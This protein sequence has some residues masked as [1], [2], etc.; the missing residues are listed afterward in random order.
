MKIGDIAKKVGKDKADVADALG[1]EKKTGYWFKDVD[2]VKAEAY[3]AA[4]GEVEPAPEPVVAEEAIQEQTASGDARFWCTG[5]WNVLEARE[6]DARDTVAFKDWVYECAP[7]G[8]EAKLLRRDDAWARF[9]V[10]EVLRGKY[11]DDRRRVDFIQY[12]ESLMFTGQT[13]ADGVSREGSK[14]VLAILFDEM[15]ETLPR[16]VKN[17]PRKLAIAVAEQVR[18]NIASF[19]TEA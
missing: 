12:L 14:Q 11:K 1:I 5:R 2:E 4:C 8:P 10:A 3:I 7:D 13:A 17:S 9:G 19:G 16:K 18:L 6:E 15:S